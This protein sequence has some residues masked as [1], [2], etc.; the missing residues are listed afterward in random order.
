[1][2]SAACLSSGLLPLPHF[3]DWM[4]DGQP[5][6]HGQARRSAAVRPRRSAIPDL[7]MQRIGDPADVTPVANR[8]KRKERDQGVLEGVDPAHEV[9][10]AR[11][12]PI[13]HGVGQ[14]DPQTDRLEGQGRQ[15]E[16]EQTE[17]IAPEQPAFLVP[18]QLLGDLDRP[19]ARV[20]PPIPLLLQD[21]QD[22]GLLLAAHFGVVVHVHGDDADATRFDQELAHQVLLP[23]VQVDGP[24]VRLVERPHRVDGADHAIGRFVDD[25]VGRADRSQRNVALR[26]A[27][28]RE[29]AITVRVARQRALAL[30]I[31]HQGEQG[32]VRLPVARLLEGQL[33]AGAQEMGPRDDRV[34]RVEDDLLETA[35]HELLRMGHEVLVERV[36][37]ADEHGQGRAVLPPDA[38]DP[39]PG[40]DYASGVPDEQAHVETADVHAQLEGARRDHSLQRAREQTALDL[41]ALLGEVAGA[42]GAHARGVA[43]RSLQEPRMQELR[44]LARLGEGDRAV[45]LVERPGEKLRRGGVRAAARVQEQEVPLGAG[46]AAPIHHGEPASREGLA[47][48]SRVGDA[49]G[50]RDET[51]PASV[52]LRH[53]QQPL[54]DVMQVRSEDPPV[55]VQLV[56]HHERQVL[57][58][59][60]PVV[61]V[62]Q[63]PEM[64]H[65][66]IGDQ[67][68]GRIGLD[69]PA[70]RVGGVPVVDRGHDRPPG[71]RQP[72][73]A[74]N[75]AAVARHGTRELGDPLQLVLRQGLVREKV[76][77]P[78]PRPQQHGLEGRQEVDQALAAGRRSDG[79]DV[80]PRPHPVDGVCLVAVEPA[81]AQVVKGPVQRRGK[82]GGQGGVRGVQGRDAGAKDDVV[83]EFL[84]PPDPLDE[85]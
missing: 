21:L 73:G 56:H 4:H 35:P 12:D 74:G 81:D 77:R 61:V 22:L 49:G 47:Q 39:L 6:S 53:A 23:V 63:D 25:R 67:D 50:G 24:R 31:Q 7:G 64:Q 41:A 69:L 65:V 43:G 19:E 78:G 34:V 10:F 9:A 38:P 66:G 29:P 82:G 8:Q 3:G 58:Q 15:V 5:D 57:E 17:P 72:V 44:D 75:Y 28:Q 68:V 14:R 16:V 18:G 32:P 54:Q 84:G 83:A 27:A 71:A 40:G 55:N 11:D 70:S 30:Q 33:G 60:T 79:Q 85:G 51:R 26:T 59:K 42:V 2:R 13:A 46:R 45:P 20:D 62:R 37:H 36:R 80:L 52:V 76:Q 48:P 1:M